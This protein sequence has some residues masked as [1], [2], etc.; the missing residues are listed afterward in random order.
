MLQQSNKGERYSSPYEFPFLYRRYDGSC[1]VKE[2][3]A[4]KEYKAYLQ[5]NAPKINMNLAKLAESVSQE[6]SVGDKYI[7]ALTKYWIPLKN[8]YTTQD[9]DRL[10]TIINNNSK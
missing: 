7:Y 8:G 5:K 4:S 6:I 9:V 2:E 3:Q 1:I 10:I